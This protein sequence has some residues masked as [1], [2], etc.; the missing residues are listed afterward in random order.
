VQ[1]RLG[2]LQGTVGTA[3][4]ILPLKHV[5]CWLPAAC[6]WDAYTG[7]MYYTLKGLGC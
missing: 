5:N 3:A 1:G 2:Y 7:Q 4:A 6:S